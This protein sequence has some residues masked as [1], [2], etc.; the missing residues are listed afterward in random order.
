MCMLRLLLL[1]A[2]A[3]GSLSLGATLAL[4]QQGY[5]GPYDFG[6]TPSAEE[7][8]AVDIDAMPDGRGLP[9]GSGTYQEGRDVFMAQ[10]AT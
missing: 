2:A 4:A 1:S 7:I 5:G 9:P 3:G 6:T 10:C 8:A